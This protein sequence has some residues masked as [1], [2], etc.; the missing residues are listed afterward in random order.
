MVNRQIFHIW[1]NLMF[2]K[3]FDDKLTGVFFV[4]V[5]ACMWLLYIGKNP[6]MTLDFSP[7]LH[8]W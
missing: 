8:V 1:V 3:Y 7:K 4:Y 5:F 6:K 2:F